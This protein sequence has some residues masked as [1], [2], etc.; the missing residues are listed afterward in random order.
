MRDSSRRACPSSEHVGS[1]G[2]KT[3]IDSEVLGMASPS[4][5]NNDVYFTSVDTQR[6]QWSALYAL[7]EKKFGHIFFSSVPLPGRYGTENPPYQWT[8]P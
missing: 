7:E 1:S 3:S 8:R 5:K 4:K 6:P 2:N